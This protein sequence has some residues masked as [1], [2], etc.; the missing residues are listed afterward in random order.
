MSV[1]VG[2]MSDVTGPSAL[3]NLR[4]EGCLIT[5]FDDR[6]SV[7]DELRADRE[8]TH[9]MYGWYARE[10]SPR[11]L[12]FA[13]G[14]IAQ[15]GE[16]LEVHCA[17]DGKIYL[18]FTGGIV[19]VSADEPLSFGSN[20]HASR[21]FHK[22]LI[23]CGFNIPVNDVYALQGPKTLTRPGQNESMTQFIPKK[24]PVEVIGVSDEPATTNG[25][26]TSPRARW[27][28]FWR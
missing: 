6:V 3:V 23:I 25:K 10:A 15:F 13:T 28:Q 18:G 7:D 21:I 2:G 19:P 5:R 12:N 14:M 27:W 20:E 8:S 4:C 24:A 22:F 1:I 26:S 11:V 16:L 17:D 9:C